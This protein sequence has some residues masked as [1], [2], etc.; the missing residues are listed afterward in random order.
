MKKDFP[1]HVQGKLDEQQAE[2]NDCSV[3]TSAVRAIGGDIVVLRNENDDSCKVKLMQD[4]IEHKA[5]EVER[6][7][8]NSERLQEQIVKAQVQDVNEVSRWSVF[9]T[10]IMRMLIARQL[11]T[12]EPPH[13]VQVAVDRVESLQ[14]EFDE[15]EKHIEEEVQRQEMQINLYGEKRQ[16][17]LGS[18]MILLLRNRETVLRLEAKLDRQRVLNHKYSKQIKTC[19][20]DH[21][22]AKLWLKNEMSSGEKFRESVN[23]E[24]RLRHSEFRKVLAQMLESVETCQK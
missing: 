2:Q 5:E 8:R 6:L 23:N 21:R 24:F 9:I 14:H 17:G 12:T 13:V 11:Q 15:Q 10:A 3:E 18:D 22:K 1:L 20:S 4:R 16:H 7:K 19:E